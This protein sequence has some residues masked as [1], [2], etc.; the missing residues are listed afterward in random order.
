M[1]SVAS[2]WLSVIYQWRWRALPYC[3]CGTLVSQL[4][5]SSNSCTMKSS[6]KRFLMCCLKTWSAICTIKL[7]GNC[8]SLSFEVSQHSCCVCNARV[9][10]L[11]VTFIGF[12]YTFQFNLCTLLRYWNHGDSVWMKIHAT[13]NYGAL[14][15]RWPSLNV[16]MPWCPQQQFSVQAWKKLAVYW[17]LFSIVF[18]LQHHS[19][20]E[21]EKAPADNTRWLKHQFC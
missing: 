1:F 19:L 18:V 10:N 11:F 6:S 20:L 14:F 9:T 3:T 13:Q 4:S 5:I 12:S 8:L 16:S 17:T 21:S 7:C 15:Q 2:Q